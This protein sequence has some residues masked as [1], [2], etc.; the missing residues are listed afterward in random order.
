MN[1]GDG[2]GMGWGPTKIS[3]KI[4]KIMLWCAV[5]RLMKVIKMGQ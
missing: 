1:Q 5:L 2:A 3:K 4:N